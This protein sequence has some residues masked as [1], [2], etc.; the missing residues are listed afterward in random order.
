MEALL[1]FREAVKLMIGNAN[2]RP[3]S[4]TKRPVIEMFETVE[5]DPESFHLKNRGITYFCNKFSFDNLSRT[6][7]ITLP[8]LPKPADP[9]LDD[10]PKYGIADGG[11]TFHVIKKTVARID[12]LRADK[13]WK[14]PFVRVHFIAGNRDSL[15]EDVAIVDA[16]NTST[17]V[18]ASTLDEYQGE[19]AEIKEAL[20][21][22]GFDLSLV[23]FRENENN[24]WNIE[25][26]LQ[27][28]ACFLQ[29]KWKVA[30]PV[31]I[32]KS[33]AKALDLYIDKETRKEF[34]RLYGVILDVIAFPEF[35][36]SELSVGGHIQR[37]SIGQLRVAIPLKKRYVRPG[38]TYPTS[39]RLHLAAILPMAAAFRELLTLRGDRYF[40]R[41]DPHKAFRD[42]ISELY[43][44]L[45]ERSNKTRSVSAL[46]ADGDYWSRCVPIVM[47]YKTDILEKELGR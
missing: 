17:Q 19:F 9:F 6:I 47:R 34:Q 11:H 41:V 27:R 42:C 43:Q 23:A 31:Q 20:A 4:E 13:D 5:E 25:E 30:Q 32:Y 36:Q 24:E 29:S 45:K 46:G 37:R 39:H 2:V 3:A 10:T 26:I 16:L 33:K 22:S 40:W 12:E 21:R 14:E 35:I 18:R 7:S 15:R 1:P 38:T 44:V 28:M 8:D